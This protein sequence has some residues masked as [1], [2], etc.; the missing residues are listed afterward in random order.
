MNKELVTPSVLASRWNIHVKTLSQWRWNGRGP[1]FLKL[2]RAIMYRLQ[3]IE[4]F[5]QERLCSDTTHALT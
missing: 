1:Q 5:E 3:D 4:A 2:G